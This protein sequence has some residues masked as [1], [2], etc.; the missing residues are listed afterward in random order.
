MAKIHAPNKQYSGVSAS[1]T[2][3]NGVGETDL[4]H[5]IEWFKGHGYEIEEEEKPGTEYE[6]MKVD[7]LKELAKEKGIED[8]NKMKR[9]ELIKALENREQVSEDDST[10]ETEEAAGD[11]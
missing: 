1:V 10:G 5:L 9:D 2:F 3:I 4:P 6:K 11:Q 7:Q 8:Y